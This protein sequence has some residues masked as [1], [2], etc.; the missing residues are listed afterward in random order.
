MAS[1]TDSQSNQVTVE[2]GGVLR[3]A[4]QQDRLITESKAILAD[5][6]EDLDEG[7]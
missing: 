6:K 1:A 3:T 2:L 4:K 5:L 7:G